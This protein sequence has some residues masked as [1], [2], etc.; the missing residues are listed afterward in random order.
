M[1][2]QAKGRVERGHR[3]HQDRLIK[4]MRLKKIATYAKAN[5]FLAEAKGLNRHPFPC[6]PSPLTRACRDY[7]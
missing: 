6:T 2:T 7:Q 1:T 4:K 3:T 5:T